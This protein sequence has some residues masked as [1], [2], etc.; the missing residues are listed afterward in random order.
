MRAGLGRLLPT[1]ARP[2]QPDPFVTLEMQARLARLAAELRELDRP[3]RL[4]LGGWHKV[5]AAQEAYER[6]LDDACELAGAAVE[7]GRGPAHRLIAEAA[8]EARGWRW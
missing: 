5:S 8:L 1:F 7:P 6:T 2:R 4:R 3:D